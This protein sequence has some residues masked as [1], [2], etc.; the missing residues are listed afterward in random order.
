VIGAAAIGAGIYFG[1]ESEELKDQ[2]DRDR[3]AGRLEADDSRITQG[4]WYAIGADAGFAIGGV[5]AVLSTINFI[6]DPLPESSAEQEPPLEFVDPKGGRVVAALN[7]GRPPLAVVPSRR[8]RRAEPEKPPVEFTAG[9]V[10]GEESGG[11]FIG[12]TF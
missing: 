5:F 8:Q 6:K 11:F 2:L 4:R 1:S 9:P 7:A 3:R 12:G 10:V